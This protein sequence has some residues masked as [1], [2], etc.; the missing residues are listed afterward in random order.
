GCYKKGIPKKAETLTMLAIR[1]GK[2]QKDKKKPQWAKGKDKGKTKLSYASKPKTSP[3]LKRDNPAKGSTCHHYKEV[4]HWRR[5]YSSY[6]AELKKR[7]NASGASTSC[8]F[9]IELY[10]FPNKTWQ[11]LRESKKL[12]QGDLSLCVGN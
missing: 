8:I 11:G 10:I 9:T 4:G 7:K 3:P 12:K 2:I 5:N 6:H 1:E